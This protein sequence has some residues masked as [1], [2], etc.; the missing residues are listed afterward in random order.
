[1]GAVVNQAPGLWG[2]VAAH[3]PFVDVLNTMLD[4]T[5]PLTPMSGLSGATRSRNK[6]AFD[7]I[8]SYSPYDQL[9]SGDYPPMLLTAGL[10]DPR[11]TYWEPAKYV[12]KLRTL[13]TDKN[14]LL[15]KTNMGRGPRRQVRKV[16][17]V[18]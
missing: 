7:Y 4:D 10:N 5:L 8:R 2:A 11:V 18:V 12:A 1:M 6:A 13:K 15:L 3:V 16:R 17:Q 9:K 14:L